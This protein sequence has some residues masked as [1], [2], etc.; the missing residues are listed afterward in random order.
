MELGCAGTLGVGLGWNGSDCVELGP[1]GI[2]GGNWDRAGPSVWNWDLPGH[3]GGTRTCWNPGAQLG[4]TGT[5]GLEPGGTRTFAVELGR[6]G[7]FCVEPG[8]VGTPSEE[9]GR[10]STLRVAP[11][12]L[13]TLR[14]APGRAE[15]RAGTG[16]SRQDHPGMEKESP[17]GATRCDPAAGQGTDTAPRSPWEEERDEDD[18]EDDDDEDVA[19]DGE[20]I[21]RYKLGLLAAVTRPQQRPQHRPASDHEHGCQ[22]TAAVPAV[23][24]ASSAPRHRGGTGQD[25]RSPDLFE[26]LQHAV[27]SLERAVF[28]RHR[29]PPAAWPLPGEAWHR[30]VKSL[31]ELSR[32]PGWARRWWPEVAAG[33]GLP[34]EVATEAARNASLRAALGHRDEEL[35]Q[36]TAAL[37]ALR[38][39]RD[40]L[41]GKPL[42]VQP[43]GT[44]PHTAL[45][46]QASAGGS[47]EQEER[48]QQL[49]GC[50]ARLQEQNR[51]LAAAFGEC[52]GEAERLSMELGQ[53]E[54][55]CTA[56]RLALRC[57]ERCGGAYAAL[58]ELVRAK[59][60]PEEDGTRGGTATEP[61]PGHAPGPGP[62][63]P[64][65][66]E[67]D[68]R[69]D[70]ADS[71]HSC[72]GMEEGALREH[73]R[74]LRAEQ[75][76]VEGSLLDTPEPAGPP[77][78]RDPRARA[79][80]ALRDARA[81][82]LPG[83]RRPEKAELLRELVVLK[84][85]LA[86]L[87]TRLQLAQWEKRA[88]D[89]LVAAQGPQEAALRLVLQHRQRERDRDRDRDEPSS[90][91][92]S[93]SSS[94]EIG[95]GGSDGSTE[96]SGCGENQ[97]GAAPDPG[98]DGAAAAPGAG[99]GAGPGAGQR[100]Q[101][102][103]AGAERRGRRGALPGAPL[104]GPGAP[105][106]PAQAGG[107][108]AAPGGAGGS[109]AEA[110]RPEGAGAGPQTARP[111]AGRRDLH[112]D[113]P[114][115]SWRRPGRSPENPQKHL[116]KP[117]KKNPTTEDTQKLP[118]ECIKIPGERNKTP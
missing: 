58:L 64:E 117:R 15:S 95:R 97:G 46:P 56:L 66:P 115:T 16:N 86:E 1:A 17:A 57:S 59:G 83:W 105:R 2:P 111:P 4:H 109:A 102:G 65:P 73:I 9:L 22:A 5:P 61:S 20:H 78:G 85:A 41:Q 101:P 81:L 47:R 82:L 55:R 33:Q 89:L 77:R 42:D 25:E 104:P 93:S 12:P 32:T 103:P 35:G 100:C 79:E 30:V 116:E 29:Q 90:S 23:P 96:P 98:Q 107:A 70:S 34:A 53:R 44:Q 114:K 113:T 43:L 69:G 27:S 38:G 91:S 92:S 60:T 74:R 11:A 99:S 75:A 6:P 37:R 87:R 106:G 52:K 49:E 28:S 76:V 10:A 94:E 31:D 50:L 62:A 19:G 72:R 13:G 84:E 36:A 118:G 7:T 110:A 18:D 14:V 8:R 68:K 67:P 88:L 40:R 3:Q 108:A 21:L 112:L 39:D 71:A 48:V 45:S 80:R 24:A 51:E 63:T 54:S 26:D